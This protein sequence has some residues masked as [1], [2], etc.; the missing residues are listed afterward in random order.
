MKWTVCE[1][2]KDGEALIIGSWK[3]SDAAILII[4]HRSGEVETDMD[5]SD[6][7]PFDPLGWPSPPNKYV[8]EARQLAR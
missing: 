2:T 6:P 3:N 4:V 5:A 1:G 7:C 8:R